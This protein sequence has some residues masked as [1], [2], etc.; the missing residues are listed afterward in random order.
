MEKYV[1]GSTLVAEGQLVPVLVLCISVITFVIATWLTRQ[2]RLRAVSGMALLRS[3]LSQ[4]VEARSAIHLALGHGGIGGWSTVE[5]AAGLTLLEHLAR[6]SA[7][8]DTPLTVSVADPT[9]LAAAQGILQRSAA[10]SEHPGGASTTAIHFVAP[11]PVAYASGAAH[12]IE[13]ERPALNVSIGTY[14]PEYLLIGE[15]GAR[16]GI[17]QVAGTTNPEALALMHTAADETLI[18]EE[19]F[20]LGAYLG[21]PLHSGSL[22]TEDVLRIVTAA[23]ILVGVVFYSLR[24]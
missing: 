1:P 18:G 6:Q 4:A 11:D 3:L 24:S 7:L 19:I 14:G 13:R 9:T 21:E 17:S 22:M 20:A 23:L 10:Q 16:H 15:A 8:C 12:L 2:R 5:T